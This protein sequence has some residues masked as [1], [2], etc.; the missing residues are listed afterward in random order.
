MNRYENSKR[1]L[2]VKRPFVALLGMVMVAL[3]WISP[4]WSDQVEFD[5]HVVHYSVFNADT[6]PAQM[7]NQYGI[8]RS[9]HLGLLNISVQKLQPQG[10]PK[11]VMAQVT[12]Q[13]VNDVGQLKVLQ[14]RQIKEGDSI[15]YISEFRVTHLER[16]KF[17]VRVQTAD[18]DQP[19]ELTFNHTFFT[20]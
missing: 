1:N 12:G 9:Q 4:A 13:A 19:M 6:L 17:T 15:Y 16:L 8:T 7:A 5:Q 14:P 10:M 18:S 11:A 20:R 2:W 3:L